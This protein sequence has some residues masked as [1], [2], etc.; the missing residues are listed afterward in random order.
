MNTIGDRVRRARLISGY[1]QDQAVE[2]MKSIGV[3]LTKGGLSK[4]ERGGSLPPARVVYALAKV[5]G[6][7]PKYILNEPQINIDWLAFRKQSSLSKAK[8]ETISALAERTVESQV[9]LQ[10]VLEPDHAPAKLPHYK[11]HTFDDAEYAAMEL[12]E[13]WNLGYAPIES[14]TEVIEDN[15][16]IV[17]EYDSGT[18][19]FDGLSGWVNQNIP[20]IVVKKTSPDDRKRFSLAHELGHLVM[21]TNGINKRDDEKLAHRFAGA[22]LVPKTTVVSILGSHRSRIAMNELK[23]L[24]L[25]YGLSMQAWVYRAKDIGIISENAFKHIMIGFNSYRKCE[26]IAYNGKEKPYQLQQLTLRALAENIISWEKAISLCSDIEK[27]D[28]QFE[29]LNSMTAINLLRMSKAD[30]YR[31]MEEAALNAAD[32]YNNNNDLRI[33]EALDAEDFYN[34]T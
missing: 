26:P 15:G 30:R 14:V 22:F 20:V 1:T 32:E 4:Y 3:T 13:V 5:F 8:Q 16:G 29:I 21:N 23:V 33:F 34:G 10:Q 9:W 31:F 12:R 25:K 27:I 11:I 17:V 7:S 18:D 24:K 6:I 2:Q 19:G 28:Q